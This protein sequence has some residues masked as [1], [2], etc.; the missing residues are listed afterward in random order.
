[1]TTH[2]G[3]HG[4][5]WALQQAHHQR[6]VRML[7]VM[8][9]AASVVLSSGPAH[10]NPPVGAT[11]ADPSPAAATVP[12]QPASQVPTPSPTPSAASTAGSAVSSS[13]SPNTSPNS[14][15]STSPSTGPSASAAAQ[16]ALQTLLNSQVGRADPALRE[17]PVSSSPAPSSTGSPASAQ[18]RMV[19]T[20]ARGQSL[21][22]LLRQHLASSPLRVEVM[23]ELVRQANPQAFVPGAGFRLVAGARLQLPSTQDQAQHAFGKVMGAPMAAPQA[24]AEERGAASATTGARR[25]WVRYP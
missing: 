10:A 21:D 24:E 7:G 3:L 11:T 6:A 15:P 13:I 16:A 17:V 18:E 1:M 12:A 25:G 14:S 9:L 4:G 22:T 23:R 5:A 2:S 20:V 19:V 8:A